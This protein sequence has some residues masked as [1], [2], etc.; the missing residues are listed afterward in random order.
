ILAGDIAAAE[1]TA[2]RAL[3]IRERSLV[4]GHPLIG[5][6]RYILG[7]AL[8]RARRL[9]EGIAE[10]ERAVAIW[11][12]RPPTAVIEVLKAMHQVVNLQRER[13][14]TESAIVAMRRAVDYTARLTSPDDKAVGA[15]LRDLASLLADAG[16][17]DDAERECERALAIF[18]S[19]L[20][21][22]NDETQKTERALEEIRRRK[23]LRQN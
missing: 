12:R 18:T 15:E 22:A 23:R 16:R 7:V 2:R 14:D 3:D 13:N 20:G 1:A 5:E 10:L 9:D 8:G 17:V 11:G 4:E 21:S 19:T 6:A